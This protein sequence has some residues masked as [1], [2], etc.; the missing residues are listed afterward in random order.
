LS[1]GIDEIKRAEAG[2]I[3]HALCAQRESQGFDLDVPVGLSVTNTVGAALR[4][5]AFLE[6]GQSL[7]LLPNPSAPP[8]RLCER[9]VDATGPLD[10]LSWHPNP[11]YARAAGVGSGRLILRSSGTSG[12]PKLIIHDRARL[13]RQAGACAHRFGLS[14]TDTVI[15]PVPLFHMFGLGAAFLPAAFAGA[16]VD[17]IADANLPRFLSHEAASRPTVAFMVPSFAETLMKGRRGA[18]TYR[19]TVMAG[20]RIREPSFV[21]YEERFGPVV[22]LYGS[23]ELG[24]VASTT[25]EDVEPLRRRSVGK[26]LPGVE[27]RLDG[28]D[29]DGLVCRH[30]DAFLGYCDEDGVLTPAAEWWPTHDRAARLDGGLEILGR[31]DDHIKRDGVLV[32]LRAVEHAVEA[33]PGVMS[34]AVV[35]GGPGPRGRELV[36]FC[37]AMPG[38]RL[39]ADALRRQLA[40]GH[41]TLVPDTIE[42][43]AQL[44][45]LATG[46]FDR[47]ALRMRATASEGVRS[48]KVLQVEPTTRCNFTCGFCAG[49]KMD[50]IDLPFEAFVQALDQLPC[51]EEL[52]L[53]GQGEPL[54]HLR[55]FD[56]AHEAKRRGIRVSTITNGSM[57]SVDRIER[58]LASGIRSLLVSIESP[59]PEEFAR[60][61]GGRLEKV[62]AGVRAL[63]EARRN[64]NLSTPTV[65]FAVTVLKGTQHEL[66]AI[67][68]L[69]REL[70]MDGG[71]ALHMLIPMGYHAAGY[72]EAMSAQLLTRT[73]QALSWVRYAKLVRDPSYAR[74]DVV[75][76][77]DNIYGYGE[78]LDAG[79]EQ[80]PHAWVHSYSRCPWLDRGLYLNRHRQLTACSRILDGDA[81][82]LGT[83]GVDP[84]DDILAR[85]GRMA[86]AVASGDPP[87]ACSGCFIAESIKIRITKLLARR[88]SATEGADAGSSSV[89]T[90]LDGSRTGEEIIAAHA[91]TNRLSDADAR[92]EILPVL[93]DLARR[94]AIRIA[95]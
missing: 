86:Q 10:R 56:M 40:L 67:A 28:P 88:L 22:Q 11:T 24:A 7:V 18:R 2:R 49:R 75:H 82:G 91:V 71:I 65:G 44:P 95:P 73:E 23:S 51:V 12:A 84:I 90:L 43:L 63:L 93:S 83:F 30:A 62:I 87:T 33:L 3:V 72:D 15:L 55:F 35:A 68:E 50:Q 27:L 48:V 80:T 85:R 61:R 21:E 77:C 92:L 42:I 34:A 41:R 29:G 59:R 64:K 14:Q 16:S 37:V 36:A 89:Q 94:G 9:I 52:E 32:S 74:S 58:L 31:T 70:G 45:L 25:P 26:P 79:S 17:L 19:L 54:S 47:Q 5:L 81:F 76:A 8:P 60:L 53:H 57:F 69:Y 1:D 66:R 4:L 39:D 78:L 6:A 38:A 13:M 20:D 46:K